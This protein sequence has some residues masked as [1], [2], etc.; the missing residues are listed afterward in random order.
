MDFF[1]NV[2]KTR[3]ETLRRRAS[4][5]L[6]RATISEGS[7]A[8]NAQ[9]PIRLDLE[10]DASQKA[11][12]IPAASG[13]PCG[14]APLPFDDLSLG[15]MFMPYNFM[16]RLLDQGGQGGYN[17]AAVQRYSLINLNYITTI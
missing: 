17:Y 9:N 4:G 3:C 1:I 14:E 11:D 12:D 16:F 7:V 15:V 5:R 10:C 13:P 8:A 2:F 6:K